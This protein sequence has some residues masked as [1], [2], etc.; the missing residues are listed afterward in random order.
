M[1]Q[2]N[3]V[4]QRQLNN[5]DDLI[6]QYSAKASELD[7]INFQINELQKKRCV[8]WD[9]LKNLDNKIGACSKTVEQLKDASNADS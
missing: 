8:L 4:Y 7:R 3:L 6:K 1:N 5:L 9:D 2:D